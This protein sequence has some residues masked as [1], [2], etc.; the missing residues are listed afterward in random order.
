MRGDQAALV[1]DRARAVHERGSS[2]GRFA[3]A[4]GAGSDA[5]AVAVALHDADARGVELQRL[6]QNQGQRRHLPL[7][8]GLRARSQHRVITSYSIHYTK[9]YEKAFQII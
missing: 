5:A 4:A 7:A 1:D 6:G 3:R 2:D 8:H 9:L